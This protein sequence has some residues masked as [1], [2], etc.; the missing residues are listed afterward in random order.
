[1]LGIAYHFG[2][3]FLCL[4]IVPFANDNRTLNFNVFIFILYTFIGKRWNHPLPGTFW[5]SQHG[6]R[7]HS[8]ERNENSVH[9]KRRQF[10]ITGR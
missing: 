3:F 4:R 10:F 9:L 7:H 2:G 5:Q 1:M 8:V 6:G